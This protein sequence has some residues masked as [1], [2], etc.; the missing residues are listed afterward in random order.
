MVFVPSPSAAVPRP[1]KREPYHHGSLREA[2]VEAGVALAREGGPAAIVL[3]E[4]ARRVGVSPNAAYRHF[5]DLRALMDAVAEAALR[6]LARSMEAEMARIHRS[7][8]AGA[9][10][11][12]RLLAVGRGY[13]H[14]ALAEPGLFAAAFSRAKESIGSGGGEGVPGGSLGPGDLLQQAL[15]ELVDA[16]LLAAEDRGAAVITA[17]A[18]VHGLSTLLLG[19]LGAVAPD[20]RQYMIESSLSLVCRGLIRR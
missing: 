9:D 10:A 19:P 6:A 15:D 20:A 3:R 12:Q 7:G 11:I 13:V 14:F 17:W 1:V 4:V 16:D 18:G 5:A 2:L 8:D